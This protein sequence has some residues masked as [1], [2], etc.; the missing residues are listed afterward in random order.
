MLGSSSHRRPNARRWALL[1]PLT[2]LAMG[3]AGCP[4]SEEGNKA[5][6]AGSASAT[7][8]A[9]ASVAPASSAT[10]SATDA[11]AAAA[12][13]AGDAA[14]YSGK[15]SVSPASY[16]IP[17]SKDWSS[18]KQAKDDPTKHVGDGTLTLVVDGEGKVTGTIDSGPAGPAVIEGSVIDGEPRGFIRRK[19]PGDQGLTGT[20]TAMAS[21]N[22]AEGK[23]SLA[24]ASAAIVREGKFSLEKN[25]KK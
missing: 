8:S 17:T 11:G 22:T 7:A 18:V 20:F 23:L 25:E 3:L 13:P 6:P 14:T 15:Y 5:G 12:K 2:A 1:F 16:Y 19:D 21:G 4:K 9:V 10:P 24:E